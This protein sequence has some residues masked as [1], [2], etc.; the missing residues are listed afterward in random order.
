MYQGNGLISTPL[1]FFRLQT[2]VIIL[3]LLGYAPF[4]GLLAKKNHTRKLRF[5]REKSFQNPKSPE[6]GSK[7]GT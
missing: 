5:E 6:L 2:Q 4:G 3:C 7:T 1:P